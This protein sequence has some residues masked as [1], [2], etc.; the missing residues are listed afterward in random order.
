MSLFFR[1]RHI[2]KK[3][4]KDDIPREDLLKNLEYAAQVLETVYIDETKWVW[5]ANDHVKLSTHV[6]ALYFLSDYLEVS[7]CDMKMN[8]CINIKKGNVFLNVGCSQ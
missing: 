7:L 4:G 8:D 3:L 2:V 6:H 1:L 5:F